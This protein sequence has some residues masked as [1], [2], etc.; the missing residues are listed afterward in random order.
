M[1]KYKTVLVGNGSSSS[2]ITYIGRRVFKEYVVL[3]G[4]ERELG[5]LTRGSDPLVTS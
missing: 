1:S 4:K 2:S 5:R 3:L